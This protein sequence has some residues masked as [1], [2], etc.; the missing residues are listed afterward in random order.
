MQSAPSQPSLDEGASPSFCA[1]RQLSE[2]AHALLWTLLHDCPQCPSRALLAKVAQSPIPMAV[3]IRHLN[4]WRAAWQLNRRKG[5]PRRAPDQRPVATGAEVVQVTPRLSYV[6]GHLFAVWLDQQGLFGTVVKQ[7]Q[8]TVEAHKRAHP[9]DDLA[10]LHHRAQTLRR[11]F[12]ALFFAPLVGIDRLTA[13]DTHEHPLGTLLGRGYHSAT[14]HQFL[15]QLERVGAAEALRPALLPETAGQIT[16]VDGVMLAY[17]S[18]LSMH[19]GKITMLGRIMAGSQALIAHNDK[20][21]ALFV[22]YHP[23]DV[24]ISQVIVAYCHQVAKTTGVPLFVVH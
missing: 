6:G 14:L 24:H 20:G 13:F 8:Q 22:T 10:L 11:R 4:R 3:S 12:Q 18:R 1:G 21:Q 19:K 9:G 15:G 16:Y 5:R 7:L 2:L 17:W 23:P